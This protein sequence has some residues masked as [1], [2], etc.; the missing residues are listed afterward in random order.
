MGRNAKARRERKQAHR[1]TV[2]RT[3]S[4]PPIDFDQTIRELQILLD[5]SKLTVPNR[6]NEDVASFCNSISDAEP[7]FIEVEPEP[8]S[9]QSSCNLNIREYIRLHGGTMI[10]GY[11]IWYHEPT[12][13]EAERHAVWF[14]DGEYKD[15]SFNADGERI[16]LF[17][18]DR[19]EKQGELG[20][21]RAKFRW[22]KDARTKQ[23]I[24]FVEVNERS[25]PTQQMDDD[26]AWKVMLTY[27]DWLKG[28]RMPSLIPTIR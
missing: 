14:K 28:K 25:I 13:M 22:A 2:I 24:E 8:W 26:T 18:P 20:L 27:E 9:R 4:T 19:A 17:L 10:C 7:F 15:I 11:K 3:V 6:V 5:P 21:N 23:L 16:V 1:N 12:Y